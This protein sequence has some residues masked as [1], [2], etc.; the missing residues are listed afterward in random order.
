MPLRLSWRI[1]SSRTVPDWVLWHILLS[2]GSFDYEMASI[3]FFSRLLTCLPW[4]VG[5]I[6]GAKVR[7]EIYEAFDNIY[8]ILKGFRKQWNFS[9]LLIVCTVFSKG[10]T[11]RMLLPSF[12]H[13]WQ[14]SPKTINYTVCGG[15]Q[16]M[17]S[18]TPSR[19]D[20]CLLGTA[21][22]S[23]EPCKWRLKLFFRLCLLVSWVSF[24]VVWMW[25]IFRASSC[26]AN[27]ALPF[28]LLLLVFVPYHFIVIE[29]GTRTGLRNNKM[30]HC[31]FEQFPQ[32]KT[33]TYQLFVSIL[34]ALCTRLLGKAFDMAWQKQGRALLI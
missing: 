3:V 17:P 25:G 32:C 7:S 28:C 1:S 26:T 2:T 4:H 30:S 19:A 33:G 29:S 22:V 27:I 16:P 8:P 15:P 18:P 24:F 31:F 12:E 21:A 13:F 9:A 23:L 14:T 20:T 10:K 34:H 11:I 6:P 5:S